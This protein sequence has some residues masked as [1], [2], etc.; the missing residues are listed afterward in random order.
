[1]TEP[2]FQRGNVLFLILIAVAL[3]AA[4]S[5][6]VTQSSRSG[7]GNTNTEKIRMNLAQIQQY[8]SS[9][10]QAVTRLRI[11][12]GCSDE[13][14]N[15]ASSNWPTPSD[16]TNSKASA[17]KKCDVFDPNAGGISWQKPPKPIQDIG[18]THYAITGV[19][20]IDG[21][22][23]GVCT[24]PGQEM[25]LFTLMPQDMCLEANKVLDI[26]NPGGDAPTASQ[27]VITINSNWSAFGYTCNN[28]PSC[29]LCGFGIGI[30]GQAPELKGKPAGCVK[31]NDG[32]YYYYETLWER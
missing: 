8:T 11:T 25:V 10:R 17:D 12:N 13:E 14:I 16:Y 6:A 21:L 28:N 9:I 23:L 29:Y 31:G 4:L 18:G 26:T 2:K 3:F 32:K 19:I 1:M 22:G 15:F 30:S 7:S 27:W 24:V 20:G 5:Y